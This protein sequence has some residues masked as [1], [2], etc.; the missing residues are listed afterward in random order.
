MGGDKK[1]MQAEWNQINEII[2][3]IGILSQLKLKTHLLP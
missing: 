2:S 1:I 3:E